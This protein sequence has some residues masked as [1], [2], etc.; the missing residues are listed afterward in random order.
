MI[1]TPLFFVSI[2]MMNVKLFGTD[3]EWENP[4]TFIVDLTV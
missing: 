3:H 1:D 4:L 2:T